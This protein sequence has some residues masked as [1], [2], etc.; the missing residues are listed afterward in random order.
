M[1]LD[2][3][4]VLST[5]TKSFTDSGISVEKILQMPEE[6]NLNKPIPIIITTHKIKKEILQKVIKDIENLDFVM[7]NITILSI[8]SN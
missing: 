1:T 8:H 2:K 6:E 3:P 5:I 7:E 4:G